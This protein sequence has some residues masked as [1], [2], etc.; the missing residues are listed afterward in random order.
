MTT[1]RHQAGITLLELLI[2]IT[3]LSLLVAGVLVSMRVGMSALQRTNS[4]VIANRRAVGAQRVIEQQIAG[5]MPIVADCVATGGPTQKIPFFQGEPGVVRFVSSY[6]L[7]EGSRGIPRVL[8][9]AIINGENNQG[10]R[11]IVNEHIYSGSLSAGRFCTGVVPD[12]VAGMPVPS[13]VPVQ[14]GT[15]SFVLADKLAGARFIFREPLFDPPFERWVSR[16]TQP[17]WPT[18]IRIEMTALE[19]DTSKITPT[20]ITLPIFV[21]RAPLGNYY[22]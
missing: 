7:N 20:N 6:S 10:F 4:R 16:W 11:L 21:N 5:L 9:F 15:N 8:E 12:P 2:S 17:F 3:L 18:A 14:V 19:A 1:R 13:F 22:D